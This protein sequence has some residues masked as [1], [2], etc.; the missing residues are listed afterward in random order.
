MV[1]AMVRVREMRMRMCE[2]CV[3][4]FVL[5]LECLM[6]LFVLMPLGQVQPDS[7]SHQQPRTQQR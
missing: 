3:G 4:T 1:M 7:E 2:R 5:V 6:H